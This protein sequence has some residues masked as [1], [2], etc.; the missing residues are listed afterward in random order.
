MEV[1]PGAQGNRAKRGQNDS[2]LCAK[3][4]GSGGLR[5]RIQMYLLM[6]LS[7]TEFDSQ[8]T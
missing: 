1:R 5:P 3:A 2:L 8:V 6:S 4:K 7:A